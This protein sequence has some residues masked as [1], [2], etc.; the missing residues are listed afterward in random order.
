MTDISQQVSPQQENPSKP[1]PSSSISPQPQKS[2]KNNWIIVGLLVGILCLCSVV[3]VAVFGTAMFKVYKE[4]A[5]VESVLDAYMTA[6][7]NKDADNAYALF[8]PR[9]QR[10]VSISQ[11]QD[12][13]EGNNFLVY[14]GYQNLSVGSINISATAN[15]NPDLPQGI[16]AKVNGVIIY[17]DDVQG[18]FNGVLEKVGDKWMIDSINVT[19]PPGKIK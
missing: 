5:P 17:A 15:T 9:A 11:I 2:K 3:C 18:H 12:L 13:L 6:M 8:S 7:A 16:V 14:K 4:K 19:V 1:L 10:Q